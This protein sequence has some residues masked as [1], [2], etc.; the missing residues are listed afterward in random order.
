QTSRFLHLRD[1]A[2]AAAAAAAAVPAVGRKKRTYAAPVHGYWFWEGADTF[3][4]ALVA[5]NN[6]ESKV[7]EETQGRFHL[8]GDPRT[9]NCSLDIRDA[10]RR[11]DGK[12]I[13][14]VERGSMKWTYKSNSLS[15][16]VTGKEWA[17]GEITGKGRGDEGR[18]GMGTPPSR[19][20]GNSVSGLRGRTWTKP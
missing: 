3:K 5:T 17:P 2:A 8:L 11:D 15:L 14:R 9:N 6:P 13:F 16:H 20:W 12:Y 4:D 19:I 7:Q 18:A 1:A 10:R